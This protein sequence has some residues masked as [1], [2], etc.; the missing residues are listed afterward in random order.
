MTVNADRSIIVKPGDWLSK[1]TM[2]IWGDYTE[3]HIKAFK[4][5]IN[6]VL[7]RIDNPNLIKAG[8]TLF[9]TSQLPGEIGILPGE[10]QSGGSLPSTK[11]D[12]NNGLLE[13]A[14]HHFDAATRLG[15]TPQTQNIAQGL[16]HFARGLWNCSA[17]RP[18]LEI[19]VL[20]FADA[21][22]LNGEDFVQRVALGLGQF[23]YSLLNCSSNPEELR[24]AIL[25]FNDAQSLSGQDQVQ[26]V[27]LGLSQFAYGLKNFS[28][29]PGL[30]QSAVLT[31]ND[32]RKPGELVQMQR[33]ALGL[34]QFARSLKA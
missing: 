4:R 28:S 20:N 5:K 13:L 29:N 16:I 32:P 10:D 17:N 3:P 26:R 11:R 6:G 2:A 27:A 23:A 9:V 19:A 14:A 12:V 15:G 30:L 8:E 18:E 25:N 7:S 33:I 21:I 1:Y 24:V 34:K 22:R 31:F